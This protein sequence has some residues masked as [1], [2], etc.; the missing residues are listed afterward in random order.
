MGVSVVCGSKDTLL[1]AYEADG[2]TTGT[3]SLL[4]RC[5]RESVLSGGLWEQNV[6]GNKNRGYELRSKGDPTFVVKQ[7]KAP[8]RS[9]EGGRAG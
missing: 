2:S 7:D 1:S 6:E 3:L 5:L 8:V 4:K 9:V